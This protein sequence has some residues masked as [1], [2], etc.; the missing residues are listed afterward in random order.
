M[1]KYLKEI[2][3]E[4]I[5]EDM[6]EEVGSAGL[7]PSEMNEPF[8]KKTD[9]TPGRVATFTSPM[10][11]VSDMQPQNNNMYVGQTPQPPKSKQN[12]KE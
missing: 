9:N 5:Y 7:A 12:E 10:R 3:S 11:G 6:T 4:S 8:S 2:P 1:A